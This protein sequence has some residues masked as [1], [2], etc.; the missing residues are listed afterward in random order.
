MLNERS[1]KL[2]ESLE[3]YIRSIGSEQEL[4]YC[5]ECSVTLFLKNGYR[6]I[7]IKSM[8]VDQISVEVFQSKEYIPSIGNIYFEDFKTKPSQRK[9]YECSAGMRTNLMPEEFALKLDNIAGSEVVNFLRERHGFMQ[10]L[11]S[12]KASISDHKSLA[13]QP[14]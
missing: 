12:V 11:V 4:D 2:V 7:S 5:N 13:P 10:Y 8:F 14:H 3:P 1:K 6:I 9:Y